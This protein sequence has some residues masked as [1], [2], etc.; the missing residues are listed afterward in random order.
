MHLNKNLD[1]FQRCMLDFCC[2]RNSGDIVECIRE[3]FR[4]TQSSIDMIYVCSVEH[5]RQIVHTFGRCNLFHF[6][7]FRRLFPHCRNHSVFLGICQK[8]IFDFCCNR[9]LDDIVECKTEAFRNTQSSIDMIYVHICGRISR[10]AHTFAHY[11]LDFRRYLEGLCLF[12]DFH[13]HQNRSFLFLFLHFDLHLLDIFPRY[14]LD[15]YCNRN[16][17]DMIFRHFHRFLDLFLRHLCHFHD[18]RRHQNR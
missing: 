10:I 16:L 3:A 17:E 2:N 13:R 11:N 14:R 12:H 4:N 8:Y 9:N 18:F 15:F 5:I 1:I 7:L 6:C